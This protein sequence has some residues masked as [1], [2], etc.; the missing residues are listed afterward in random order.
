MP[1]IHTNEF[2]NYI[3]DE[4]P[5]TL[6][7][8]KDILT[9]KEFNFDTRSYNLHKFYQTIGKYLD[10][11]ILRFPAGLTKY[12]QEKIGLGIEYKEK[13][14]K[15]Y[16]EKE[17]RDI[18][19]KIPE[20]NP[21][22]EIRDYQIDA[23][24]ASLNNFSSLISATV[25]SGKE[26]PLDII[27]PT[28]NG[29]K[30]F[31]SLK[32]GD[33]VFG[34]DGKPQKVI[35]IFPQGSKD[36]YEVS[37][38]NGARVE[39]GLEHLWTV[40]KNRGGIHTITLAEI[41]KKYYKIDKRGFKTYLYSV[42]YCNPVQYPEK[43]YFISPY[44][45][46]I[47]I[48]DGTLTTN[49][50]GFSCPDK[51]KE[52][53]GYI[54]PL[55]D[56]NYHL[57]CDFKA[58][59]KYAKNKCS[60][61]YIRL[62]NKHSKNKY[63]Q[64]IIRLALN[65]K[66]HLKK[67]P[68]EYLLGSI[69]QRKELLAGL[70]D[71]DDCCRKRSKTCSITYGTTSKILAKNVQ[72]LVFSLGGAAT[73]REYTRNDRHTEYE[74]SIEVI[75][76]P[77]KLKNKANNFSPY[78]VCN[79]IT[80][81]KW[82]RKA[83]AQCIKVSNSDELY[84]TQNYIPTHNTS[85]MSMVCKILSDDFIL[86][87]NGNNFILQQIYDRL[88]SIGV[89][90]ISWNPSKDPDYS[91]QIVLINTK[92]SDSK[93]NNQDQDYI[94]FLN[95]I[96][97]LIWDEAHHV[98]ALTSFEP[99]FYTNPDNLHHI[100]G[101]SGSP[102]RNP[103]RVYKNLEDFITV[104]ILGEPAFTYN[105]ADTIADGNIAQPYSYFINFANRPGWVPVGMEDNYFMQYRSNIVY[106]KARNKA[107]MAMLRFL[108]QNNIKTLASF[109]NIKPGQNMLKE[110]KENGVD[111]LFICGDN[112]IYEWKQ[113]KRG[114]LKLETRSGTTEDVREAL[115]SGYNIIVG[116]SVLDEGVDLSEF[117]AVVLFSAGK[118]CISN[119]QRIGRASRKRIKGQNVSLVIDFKDINGYY[120]FQNHYEQRKAM[121]KK[122]GVKNIED[123]Q[124]FMKLVEE[125]GKDNAK[126]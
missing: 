81:I 56:P 66:S 106:N 22:F 55:L 25:G 39:C 125:L 99:L 19:S 115:H 95:K 109:N 21:K 126:S 70:L 104:A 101:Y 32:L 108:N 3:V 92:L 29:F 68:E 83:E 11:E 69:N 9:F 78:R 110:L 7:Q 34:K 59:Y 82:I 84:L 103:D 96:N 113:T 12:L 38:Q 57:Q 35:G 6:Y 26:Q 74:V 63:K 58:T 111:G 124:E 48:G 79:T 20:I 24:L 73:V 37:F 114:K 100:I 42:D 1:I 123:V 86:I 107:G 30:Q 91:K 90:D 51:E 33:K 8:I 16:T 10:D 41:M 52:I 93:L 17:V 15:E 54:S 18:V 75:F 46:G 118:T 97:T 94:R 122:C 116:S 44:L 77:F 85:I 36:I 119:I 88:T 14:F 64:E 121:M 13:S 105:M 60:Q 50:I 28:P 112:T 72:Q 47:L 80:N 2:W 23:V 76:N 5:A 62:N 102:F 98:Q 65:V 87:M 27:I 49:N 89:T 45:L 53:I 117:Q 67:I 71:S 120:I 31:G 61:Y 40:C 4:Q 43:E